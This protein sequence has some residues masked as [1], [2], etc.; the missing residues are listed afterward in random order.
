MQQK[1]ISSSSFERHYCRIN[2][3]RIDAVRGSRA[4]TRTSAGAARTQRKPTGKVQAQRQSCSL[5]QLRTNVKRTCNS[6][7]RR[8]CRKA[9]TQ[10]KKAHGIIIISSHRGWHGLPL[11]GTAG[12]RGS[13][14]FSFSC[15]ETFSCYLLQLNIY[16]SSRHFSWLLHHYTVWISH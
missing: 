11:R 10:H 15:S 2:G 4:G 1:N 8:V 7:A 16:S 3:R 9:W 14:F 6:S 12:G 13:F 5:W